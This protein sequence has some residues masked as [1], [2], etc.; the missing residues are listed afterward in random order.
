MSVDSFVYTSIFHSHISTSALQHK[1]LEATIVDCK[2]RYLT[3][4]HNYVLLGLLRSVQN[5]KFILL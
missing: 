3:E 4:I 5:S 2:K 1:T